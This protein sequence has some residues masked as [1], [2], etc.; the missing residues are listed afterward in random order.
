VAICVSRHYRS[1][2]QPSEYTESKPS[3]SGIDA[4]S[5]G[6]SPGA[7]AVGAATPQPQFTAT[8]ALTP[9]PIIPVVTVSQNTNCRSGPS[10]QYNI[11][12]SLLIGQTAEVVGKSAFANNYWVIKN[13]DGGYAGYGVNTRP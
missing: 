5:V 13:S 7:P 1:G 2:M 3:R 6:L 9:T 12:G 4:H 10:T 8:T 11:V